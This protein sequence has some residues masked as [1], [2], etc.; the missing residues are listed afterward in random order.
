MFKE[1]LEDISGIG[2]YPMFSLMVFFLFFS[3]I[4]IWVL[5]TKKDVFLNDSMLPLNN[6]NTEDL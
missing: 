6:N 1:I 4:F 2:L 5:K 3:G